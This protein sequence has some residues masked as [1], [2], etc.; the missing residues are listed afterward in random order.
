MARLT[1]DRHVEADILALIKACDASPTGLARRAPGL[2]V[3]LTGHRGHAAAPDAH[4][5]LIEAVDTLTKPAAHAARALLHLGKTDRETLTKR[6]VE[7][8]KAYGVGP[9]HFRREYQ[10]NVITALAIAL[11]ERADPHATYPSTR[12]IPTLIPPP[13]S[14][15]VPRLRRAPRAA[16]PAR[17]PAQP[18]R[19]APLAEP[20]AGVSTCSA[21][22][23]PL[24]T[25]RARS[26]QRR[27]LPVAGSAPAAPTS[28]IRP[29]GT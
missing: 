7:A 2:V 13:L 1:L 19:T 27:R 15:F 14:A 20:V 29:T 22:A 4:K 10:P 11:L 28:D 23:T 24:A 6:R 17:V 8:A 26:G 12:G 5:I 25:V 3:L 21:A 16:R 18:Q 9:T